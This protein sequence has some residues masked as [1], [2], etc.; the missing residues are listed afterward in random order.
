MN[1][2]L[3]PSFCPMTLQVQ[4]L[5]D[6]ELADEEIPAVQ[7]HLE[8]CSRCAD[9]FASFEKTSQMFADIVPPPDSSWQHDLLWDLKVQTTRDLRFVRQIAAVAAILVAGLSA[10]SFTLNSSTVKTDTSPYAA[11]DQWSGYST[12]S[13]NEVASTFVQELS[14]AQQ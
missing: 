12:R 1:E 6:G 8:E 11:I 13:S 2:E 7:Q 10:V 5:F 9:Y 3:D 14:E 4:R